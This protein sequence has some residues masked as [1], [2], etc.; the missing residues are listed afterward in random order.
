MKSIKPRTVDLVV[1]GDDRGALGAA[2]E[3]VQRGQRVMVV[4]RS[5]D[6]RAVQDYRRRL[7]PPAN[8]DGGRLTV[9]SN[10]EVVCVDGVGGVEAVVIRHSRT[11]HLYA[12]NASAFL[13]CERLTCPAPVGRRL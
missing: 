2:I 10:A 8:C 13:S 6:A 3:A 11:G 12:V 4:L 1:T 9:V 7:R 5:R